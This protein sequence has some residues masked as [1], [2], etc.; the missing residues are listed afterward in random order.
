MRIGV[1]DTILVALFAALTAA[2]AFVKVPVGPAPISL[3]FFFTALAGI[4]LGPYLGLLSQL[5]YVLVGLLGVPVFTA[6]GGPSYVVHPTFG[7][8]LGFIGASF[9]IGKVARS[10]PEPSLPRLV[11][12]CVAGL[13]MI[14]ALGVPYMFLVLKYVART[15]MTFTKALLSGFLVFVPGDLAKSIIAAYVGVRLIPQIKL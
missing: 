10:V 13:L 3:Q 7:Y 14:Y 9:I 8:L 4:L 5:V 12:G 1:K 2:G 15:P 11:A 6:G